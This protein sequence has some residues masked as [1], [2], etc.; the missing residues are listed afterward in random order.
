MSSASRGDLFARIVGFLVFCIGI[1]IILGVVGLAFR[2]FI[3]PNLGRVATN[4]KGEIS[5]AEVGSGFGR[6]V[7]RIVLLFLASLCGSLIAN[8]GI[9]LY[10]SALQNG[11]TKTQS[12]KDD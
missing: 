11:I 10:F 8:K 1:T 7:F 6:L 9:N 4:P 3:D 12:R 2:M 5:V